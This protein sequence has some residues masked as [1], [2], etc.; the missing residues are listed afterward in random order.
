VEPLERHAGPPWN[1]LAC[2]FAWPSKRPAFR[3]IRPVRGYALP[4]STGRGSSGAQLVYVMRAADPGVY[5]FENVTVDYRVGDEQF[6][7]LIPTGLKACI[8][9]EGVKRDVDRCPATD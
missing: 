5:A 9:P 8:L 1:A 3:S 6:R 2:D 7:A 4:A